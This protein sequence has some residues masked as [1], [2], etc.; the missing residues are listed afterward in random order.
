MTKIIDCHTH[1]F[2][3][4]FIPIQ[5][6][7]RAR[8]VPEPLPLT[9]AMIL[10]RLLER[11]RTAF[12]A[13]SDDHV[14]GLVNRAL[15]RK[16]G[17]N[18]LQG[19]DY[20]TRYAS[21]VSAAALEDLR[22][23]LMNPELDPHLQ[24]GTR[25]KVET[26]RKQF[27]LAEGHA[28]LRARLE[29]ILR[30]VDQ[31]AGLLETGEDE[32]HILGL[33]LF[34]VM[35][36]LSLLVQHESRIVEAFKPA[37]ENSDDMVGQVHQMMDMHLHYGGRAPVY[38]F[39]SEQIAR[40]VAVQ[41]YA[42][43]PLA[44]FVAFDPF[45]DDSQRMQIIRD[46]VDKKGFVGVK[47]YP[48]NGYK[49]LQNTPKDIPDGPK[50]QVV[51]DRNM[52][53]FKWCAATDTPMFAHCS[54]GGMESR[55]NQTG[56]FSWPG[57]WR[58]ILDQPGLSKL[59]LCLG[60]AGGDEGWIAPINPADDR[61]WECSYAAIVAYLCQNYDNVYCDFAYFDSILDGA[62]DN[63]G[64]RLAWA[65]EK[66]PKLGL[67]ICYGTDWHLL[68]VKNKCSEYALILRGILDGQDALKPFIDD[69]FYRNTLRF[70]GPKKP[71][72]FPSWQSS[73]PQ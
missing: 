68:M 56:A 30:E 10:E 6:V 49:P 43:V 2:N 27:A 51:N 5:G 72:N 22:A 37:W 54:L 14:I 41:Q 3:V 24:P 17:F 38:E 7:L 66:F 9:I 19:D 35:K 62:G 21:A 42:S 4:G 44:G 18:I 15:T 53:F 20:Y 65:V 58:T 1:V 70:L 40:M 61:A 48:P 16:A 33:S 60:H 39:G 25:A 59:R 69:F 55:R 57:Y 47:F 34:G 29:T 71:A 52:D 23:V 67:K 63:F 26:Q 11:E 12:A 36:W 64:K 32:Q 73:Q 28:D 50:A 45:R 46:A 31:R 8:E 13:V